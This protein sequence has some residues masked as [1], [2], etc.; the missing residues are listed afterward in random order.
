MG[1]A[2]KQELNFATR[3]RIYFSERFP[4]LQHGTLITAF[5]IGAMGYSA[6]LQG[7]AHFP[8]VMPI[9]SAIIVTILFFLQLRIFDEFKDFEDDAR[10]RPYRPVPRGIVTLHSLAWLWIWAVAVQVVLA[11]LFD[12]RLLLLLVVIWAYSGL[13]A[14]EFFVRDWLKAHPVA[15]MVSHMVIVPM[16][17]L[18]IT[19]YDWLDEGVPDRHI[20]W[21]LALSYFGFSIIE[22]GRKIRAREDEEEGVETYSAL[23]GMRNAVAVWLLLMGLAGGLAITA[24]LQIGTPVATVSYVVLMFGVSLAVGL[25]FLKQPRPGRGK[26]FQLLSGLWTVGIYLV[27]G[28]VPWLL[29]A[30]ASP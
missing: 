3:W 10:W 15:Y 29:N 1:V 11:F 19:A 13:M 25:G 6:R 5:V 23:W 27:V 14:V 17:A 22:I 12:Q 2:R 8:G 21:L 20:G 28:V 9:L 7:H 4:P 30:G 18:Y 16:I 24:S 26:Q